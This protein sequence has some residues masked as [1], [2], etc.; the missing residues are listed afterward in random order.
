M[1]VRDRIPEGLR[2]EALKTV[3]R[4]SQA[5][6]L[7]PYLTQRISKEGAVLEVS[8]ISTALVNEEGEMYA[9]ATT[10]RLREPDKGSEGVAQ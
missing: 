7:E 4:L 5:E 10:E 1:N 9:V 3:L 8:V 2:D 6:I